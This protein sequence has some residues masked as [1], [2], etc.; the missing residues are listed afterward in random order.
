MRQ[1]SRFNAA[2]SRF[3]AYFYSFFE[4]NGNSIKLIEAG[5]IKIKTTILQEQIVVM[6][7]GFALI[8]GKHRASFGKVAGDWEW[9][10][11][12]DW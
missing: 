11:T 4:K 7:E 10:V 9:L 6:T 2:F 12:S 1:F 3:P 8:F 5:L